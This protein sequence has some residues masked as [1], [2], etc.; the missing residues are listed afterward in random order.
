MAVNLPR[1]DSPIVGYML[2]AAIVMSVIP[3]LPHAAGRLQV[4]SRPLAKDEIQE[5]WVVDLENVG[6]G[7]LEITG[8]SAACKC[9]RLTGGPTSAS[10]SPGVRVSVTATVV[11]KEKPEDGASLVIESS[12]LL[13]PVVDVRL[14][15]GRK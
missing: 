10:L 7:D 12:D 13:R 8:V 14:E 4:S 9:V 6:G 15:R 5:S 1:F 3:Y 2:A 11:L